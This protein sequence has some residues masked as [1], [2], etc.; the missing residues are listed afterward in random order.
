MRRLVTSPVSYGVWAVVVL[1]ALVGTYPV[2]P[3]LYG[4]TTL[5]LAW[6]TGPVALVGLAG[7]ALAEGWARRLRIFVYV[8][9]AAGAVAEAL[10]ILS[11]FKWN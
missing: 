2:D 7:I 9:I 8:A 11:K 1:A 4:F 10:A 3:Y 5:G 6:L